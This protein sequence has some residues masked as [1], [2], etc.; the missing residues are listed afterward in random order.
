MAGYLKVNV[1]KLEVQ[2]INT[3]VNSEILE[4]FQKKCKERNLQ[5]CTVIETFARQYANG[6]Y[7]LDTDDI[8]KWK[9]DN[10]ETSTINTP[11][12]KDVYIKFKNAVK[13]QGFFVKHVLSAFIEDYAKSEMVFEL[14]S[15]EMT[16][17][18]K[19][20]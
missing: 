10:G 7:Y 15:A 3:K 12:N 18:L 20:E 5:M 14:V 11:V 8:L 2:P 4:E 13:S 16:E 17:E 1:K 6:R 19:E 9:N